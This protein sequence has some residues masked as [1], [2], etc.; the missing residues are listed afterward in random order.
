MIARAVNARWIVA[1]LIITQWIVAGLFAVVMSGLLS[2]EEFRPT[3]TQVTKQEVWQTVRAD[4]RHRGL[5]DNQLP[6]VEDIDLPMAPPAL[7]GRSL[8]V[9]SVC[10]DEG[11]R[12]T[13]FRLECGAPGQCLPFL[14]YV[15]E[16]PDHLAADIAGHTQ[17]CRLASAASPVPKS[18]LASEA[19]PKPAVRNGDRATAVF[20]ST[21]M[22]MTASVTCLERGHEGEVIRVRSPDGHIFRARISGPSLVEALPQ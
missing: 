8:R 15:R 16:S 22:R 10:W 6:R 18:H 7:P 2:A 3:L 11:P 13:Q 9:A 14:V 12:R 1:R 5:A 20:L 19:V 4:L 21:N 17:S